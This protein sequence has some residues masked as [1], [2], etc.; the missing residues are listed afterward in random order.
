MRQQLSSPKQ[1]PCLGLLFFL[2]NIP[3]S[4]ATSAADPPRFVFGEQLGGR[5]PA[6]LI[7]EMEGGAS[8]GR[9]SL[10][11]EVRASDELNNNAIDRRNTRNAGRR[12]YRSSMR[13]GYSAV[14][15]M[16]CPRLRR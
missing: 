13:E 15:K 5:A 1:L 4:F 6:G 2:F 11:C 7:L 16:V 12:N 10:L 14:P 9:L 3:Y 8:G